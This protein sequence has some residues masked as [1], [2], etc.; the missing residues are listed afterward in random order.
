MEIFYDNLRKFQ[1]YEI[2]ASK[3][4]EAKFNIKTKRFCNTNRYD[5]KTTDNIKDE[6][7]TEPSSLRTGNF[8]IEFSGYGKPSG[9]AVTKSNFNI[10][11]DTI[12]YY[13]ISTLILKE[14]ISNNTFKIITTK[15]NKTIGYLVNKNIVIA[16]SILI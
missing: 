10:I 8:F 9:I 16:A 1:P 7:K 6:V 4:I 15:D 5:F 2:E 13:L 3:R 11:S 14:I 12:N